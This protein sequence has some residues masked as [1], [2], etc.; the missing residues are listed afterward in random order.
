MNTQ[1]LFKVQTNFTHL[2]YLNQKRAPSLA[3]LA[4]DE[5]RSL[6]TGVIF[7][8]CFVNNDMMMITL[9]TMDSLNQEAFKLAQNAIRRNRLPLKVEFVGSKWQTF[10]PHLSITYKAKTKV[11]VVHTVFNRNKIGSSL[12]N[13]L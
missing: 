2:D 8:K 1:P 5:F 10:A 7:H 13:I 6:C 3:E 11:D 4:F 9:C 12:N